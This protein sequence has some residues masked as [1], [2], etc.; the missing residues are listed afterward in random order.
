M[1]SLAAAAVRWPPASH[2]AA[3]CRTLLVACLP[4]AACGC[5]LAAPGESWLLL[6]LPLLPA[7]GAPAGLS[8]S[9]LLLL[10]VAAAAAAPYAV[11]LRPASDDAAEALQQQIQAMLAPAR[12]MCVPRF[13][14]ESKAYEQ[15]CE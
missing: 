11:P 5:L 1:H 15:G 12:V 14:L 6:L 4:A 8:C 7:V 9:L 3:A 13:S 2:C 10:A